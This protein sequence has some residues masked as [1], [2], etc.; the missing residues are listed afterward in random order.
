MG[1]EVPAS[2]LGSFLQVMRAAQNLAFSQLGFAARWAPGPDPVTGLL[3]RVN[4][5]KF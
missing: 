4:V 1:A 2:V 5:I 3:V